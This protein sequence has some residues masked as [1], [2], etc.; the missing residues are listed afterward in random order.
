MLNYYKSRSYYASGWGFRY[1]VAVVLL[2]FCLAAFFPGTSGA[3]YPP[4][5]PT[6]T[7]T[8]TVNPALA[9]PPVINTVQ[10]GA[11]APAG[12]GRDFW[13]FGWA[14]GSIPWLKSDHSQVPALP[15]R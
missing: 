4:V 15:K 2:G 3:Q 12:A 7:P 13:S 10:T 5:P 8:P 11:T 9:Q 6:P 14:Q 1:M